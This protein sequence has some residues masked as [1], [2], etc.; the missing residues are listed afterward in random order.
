MIATF[1]RMTRFCWETLSQSKFTTYYFQNTHSSEWEGSLEQI[2]ATILLTSQKTKY[3]KIAR[4]ICLGRLQSWLDWNC[5]F[6][7]F[8][9]FD[10]F[11][12]VLKTNQYKTFPYNQE[13]KQSN[14]IWFFSVK[15]WRK[16]T[17]SNKW[18]KMKNRSNPA[19][20]SDT[21]SVVERGNNS[22][23]FLKCYNDI[24]QYI[25]LYYYLRIST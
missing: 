3:Q 23:R 5:R 15:I 16:L 24:T 20:R 8:W 14:K 10:E 2:F 12:F 4:E 13:T 11:C 17:K 18:T 9:N 7:S 1:D 21:F 19:V 25:Q 22:K 6:I